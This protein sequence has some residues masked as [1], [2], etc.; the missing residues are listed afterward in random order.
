M[1][2]CIVP[3]GYMPI[4][5]TKGGAVETLVQ[6]I[7]NK[8]EECREFSITVLSVYDDKA[9][10]IANTYKNCEVVFLKGK[11]K[12]DKIY[13]WFFYKVLK[14]FVNVILP[15]YFLRLKMIKYIAQKQ[16]QYDWIIFEGGEIDCL[17]YYKRYIDSNKII[18]HSHGEIYNKKHLDFCYKYYL[19]VSDF[20]GKAWNSTVN[21]ENK[22]CI[23][24]K[25]GVK[26]SDFNKQLSSEEKNSLKK[27]LGIGDNDFV[28]MF[29]GRIIPEK[30]VKELIKAIGLLKE[31][32][33]LLMIGSSGFGIKTKTKY[34]KEVVELVEKQKDK[35]IFTGYVDNKEVYKYYNISDM[36]A[37]PSMFNDPAPLVIIEA[38]AA[39][40]PIVTTGSGGIKEFCDDECAIFIDRDNDF[41]NNLEKAI[42]Y[43]KKN[44]YIREK[45][46]EH[47]K[48]IVR[49]YTLE[50]YYNDF[51]NILNNISKG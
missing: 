39:G 4:P 44:P 9:E 10:K 14:K 29:I 31:D 13:F 24:L 30:G 46:S 23:T 27:K 41:C 21:R 22:Y 11:P 50:K 42:S 6:N 34:E 26:I 3:A 37:V 16:E 8:N 32:I 28:I 49:N 20:V 7:I 33:K 18:I 1:K 43:L 48:R 45:M 17:K 36:I 40:V 35:I 15:D 51:V 19:S 38:M 5:A 2:I 25:N 12:I 47:G